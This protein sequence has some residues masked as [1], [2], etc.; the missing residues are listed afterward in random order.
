MMKRIFI[1]L[2][3]LFCCTINGQSK[4]VVHI[5]AEF[6]QS[7]D[8]YGLDAV[9]DVKVYNGYIDNN[10]AI[11]EKYNITRVPTLLLFVGGK[12]VERWEAGLDMTLHVGTKEVQ[13]II[14]S[15]K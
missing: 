2:A 4:A 13:K 6:N 11:K 10:P 8:W 3:F 7:N 15:H 5:N 9:D 1:V 14:D 12:E